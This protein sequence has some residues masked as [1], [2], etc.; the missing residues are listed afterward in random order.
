[1]LVMITNNLVCCIADQCD[2]AHNTPAAF[3]GDNLF[4]GGVRMRV[5]RR[6]VWSEKYGENV[7]YYVC[8]KR[9]C[10]V[11]ATLLRSYVLVHVYKVVD[12]TQIRKSA[13]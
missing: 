5:N 6:D 11:R 1:M 13:G 2:D 7:T 3:H 4:V 9:G 10:K 12:T 8:G